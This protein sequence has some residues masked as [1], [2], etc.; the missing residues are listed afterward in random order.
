MHVGTLRQLT[1]R[2]HLIDVELGRAVEPLKEAL[3]LPVLRNRGVVVELAVHATVA[4]PL[5]ATP[6]H[7][8]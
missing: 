3:L 1:A 5:Q 7:A 2:G 6:R 8:T 4:S